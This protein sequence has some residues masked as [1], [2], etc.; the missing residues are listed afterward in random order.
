[1][2]KANMLQ[3]VAQGIIAQARVLGG[4]IGI[5]AS[6]AILSKMQHRYL[7]S[8]LTPSQ[9][10]T[11]ESTSHTLTPDQ[12]LAVR[13]AYAAAFSESMKVCAAVSAACV[14]ATL[15]TYRRKPIVIME[16]RGEQVREYTELMMREGRERA[17]QQ[18]QKQA[19]KQA[20]SSGSSREL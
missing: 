4:S 10:S 20:G 15:V 17:M 3:A 6:T 9:L 19:Q 18:A 12:L 2:T 16:R 1:M 5:A 13:K 14:F 11:L 7:S 8:L